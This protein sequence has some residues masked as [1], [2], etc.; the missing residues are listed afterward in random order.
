M[1][2]LT[3]VD[4]HISMRPISPAAA[5]L[6]PFC[7]KFVCDLLFCAV[8]QKTELKLQNYSINNRTDLFKL[9]HIIINCIKTNSAD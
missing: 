5:E 2:L 9:L 8:I 4:M 6:V 3:I 7:V 1:Y